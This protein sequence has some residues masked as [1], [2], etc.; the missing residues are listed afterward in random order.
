[1]FNNH[2]RRLHKIQILIRDLLKEFSYFSFR[3]FVVSKERRS[4]DRKVLLRPEEF[5]FMTISPSSIKEKC[6]GVLSEMLGG[7]CGAILG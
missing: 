5:R 6:P 2:K 3:F 4:E 1:M 7:I